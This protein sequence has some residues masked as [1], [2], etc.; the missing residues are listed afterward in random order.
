MS[1]TTKRKRNPAVYF[2]RTAEYALRAMA[3][4]ARLPEGQ[5]VRAQELSE[6]ADIPTPYLS[7]IMRKLVL[8]GLL[9]SKKGHGG[10]FLLA[11]PARVIRFLDVLA[12]AD[13]ETNPDECAFGWGECDP[14][15]PCPLHPSWARLRDSFIEWAAGMTLAD[16]KDAPYLPRDFVPGTAAL[17]ERLPVAPTGAKAKAKA[18]STAKAKLR[19]RREPIRQPKLR[20]KPGPGRP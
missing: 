18:V 8:A 9:K 5:G 15:H 3:H 2:P 16:V 4:M 1:T 6:A 19:P 20:T 13:Y 7:K 11:R 14:N 17:T 12:A 10:G